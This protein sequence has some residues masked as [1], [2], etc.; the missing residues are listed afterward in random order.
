M[1]FT[2][3]QVRALGRSVAPRHIRSRVRDGKELNYVEGWFAIAE[4]NRIFGFDGWDRETLEA[5]CVLSREARGSFSRGLQREGPADRAG[6]RPRHRAGR[7]RYRRGT[8]GLAG[9]SA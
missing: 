7:L 8:R 1:S 3:Q 9:R 6:G 5:K 4:A 2:E